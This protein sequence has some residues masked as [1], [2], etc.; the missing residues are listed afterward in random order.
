MAEGHPKGTLFGKPK[1]EVIKHPGAL[2]RELGVAQGKK[3]PEAKL[4]KAE[5]SKNPKLRR[6]AALA[7]TLK[8]FHHGR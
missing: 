5:H 2:H 4:A 7:E 3:I 8:G 6:R 1:N